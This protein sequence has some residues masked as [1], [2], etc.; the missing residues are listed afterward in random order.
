M[1]T[2]M[3]PLRGAVELGE[4]DAG[5]ADA[6]GEFARLRQSVLPGGG[7][8]NQQDVV[9]RAGNDFGG[10]ALH[11]FELGHQVGFGVQAAGGV[12]DDHVGAARFGGGQRVEDDGG[13]IGAGFL[14][15]HF[16]AVAL[17]PDFELLD[18][19]GAKGV[20]GAEHHAASFL[21]QAI[22]ELADAG[23]FAG[24]VD[25]DDENDARIVAIR[26]RQRVSGE[27]P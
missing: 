27:A 17:R 5:D 10:G 24:A 9:R 2:T 4:N 3:P 7:V 22:R 12:D 1:A 6:G 19:G 16:D 14:L 20:G 11:F 18:G 26:R 21:A 13:G 15:D 25:A 23:G 8:E